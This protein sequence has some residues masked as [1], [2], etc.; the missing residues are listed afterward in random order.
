[1]CPKNVTSS[2]RISFVIGYEK[3]LL[4]STASFRGDYPGTVLGGVILEAGQIGA[5]LAHIDGNQG[6]AYAEE[7]R[8]AG[9]IEGIRDGDV[10]DAV[11]AQ[12]ALN[13]I[14]GYFQDAEGE[15]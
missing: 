9:D 1:G 6:V 4:L 12:Q 13:S 14:D 3:I 15:A 7:G 5:G 10:E 2:C 8:L 11:Y